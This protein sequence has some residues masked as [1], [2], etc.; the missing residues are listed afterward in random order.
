MGSGKTTLGKRL[1]KKINK[2]YFDLDA[3]IE[4]RE[5]VTINELFEQ[6]GEDYFRTIERQT[7]IDLIESNESF[8]MSL[9]GG[10][11]CY[12]DN[13]E[14]INRS[15]ISIYLKYNSGMLVSRLLNA[16]TKRPLIKNMD[17]EA[18]NK[19]VVKKLNERELY[20]SKGSLVVESAN[21]KVDHLVEL[22]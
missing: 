8:V 6:H 20:Y 15:G 14:V 1:A 11:P 9:G 7:L 3:E 12:L 13:M 10:T 16:Q 18:L 17:K 5:D 19:F 2:T 21:I 4:K 22:L